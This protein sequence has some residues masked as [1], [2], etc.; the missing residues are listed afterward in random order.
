MSHGT[1]G[2]LNPLN[3]DITN[4]R[5]VELIINEIEGFENIERKQRAFRADQILT[6]NQKFYVKDAI[7]EKY[8]DSWENFRL[9]DISLAKKVIEKKGKAYKNAP[10]RA[11]DN[12]AQ[13][14]AYADIFKIGKFSRA[15]KEADQIFN[16][17]KYVA[18]WVKWIEDKEDPEDE[19]DRGGFYALQALKPFEYDLIRDPRTG[20]P[21]IFIM[22][23]PDNDITRSTGKNDA[24]EQTITDSKADISANTEKFAIW[25]KTQHV[26]VIRRQVE[27]EDENGKPIIVEEFEILSVNPDNVNPFAPKLPISFL[28]KETGPQYP[29]EN[30]LSQQSVDFNVGYSNLLTSTDAQGHGQ[31]VYSHPAKQEVK[32]LHM[33]LHTAIDVPL[34]PEGKGRESKVEYINASPDLTGQLEVLQFQGQQTLDEHGIRS[35]GKIGGGAESFASGFDRLLSEAD[36]LEIIEDNQ[37]LYAETLEQDIYQIIQSSEETLERNI[38]ETEEIT[39]LYPKPKVLISDKETIAN[40]K[41]QREEGL[42]FGWEKHIIMNPNLS[43]TA[44]RKR[45]EEIQAEIKKERDE[46]AVFEN[47][48]INNSPN[49]M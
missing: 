23:L 32:K 16:Y 25:S 9:G 35:K 12:D 49:I 8:P 48:M 10:I 28:S 39:V 46:Q 36:C 13:T 2:V 5:H 7:R 31:L 43:E 38:F 27:I 45:E 41:S 15:F 37:S 21:L 34:A 3:V 18:L 42:V 26:Q 14:D 11:L 24:I 44:A 17:Y 33:G 1:T 19:D 30:N 22:S 47:K 29:T 20:E 40:I 4:E 6:G